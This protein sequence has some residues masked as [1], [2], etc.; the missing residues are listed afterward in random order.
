[1]SQIG[2]PFNRGYFS[3]FFYL[4]FYLLKTLVKLTLC[5][6]LCTV[7]CRY[8]KRPDTLDLGL[9]P[10]VLYLVMGNTLWSSTRAV[11]ML[12]SESSLHLLLSLP[13]IID[14]VFLFLHTSN[15]LFH[16][17]F[18]TFCHTTPKKITCFLPHLMRLIL[19]SNSVSGTY[20]P[21]SVYIF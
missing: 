16:R 10:F 18:Y 12:T 3:L 5:I 9:P 21:F 20:I 19:N 15:N 1:M 2:L 11:S 4:S 6:W 8:L 17:H 13:M 14:H 7:M